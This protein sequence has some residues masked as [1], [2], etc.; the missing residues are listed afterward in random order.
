MEGALKDYDQA[1]ALNGG[2]APAHLRKGLVLKQIQGRDEE[3][4]KEI[5]TALTLDPSLKDQVDKNAF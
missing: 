4:Q 2:Y 1:L 5:G 3:A